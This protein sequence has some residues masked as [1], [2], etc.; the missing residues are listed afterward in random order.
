[1]ATYTCLVEQGDLT[2]RETVQK[3]VT[4]WQNDPDLLA[5]RDRNCLAAMPVAEQGRWQQ[6][7]ADVGNLL[8]T[9][10]AER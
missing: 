9:V 10:R 8:R 5:V 2:T 4:H 7:W 3:D 6:L 1:L